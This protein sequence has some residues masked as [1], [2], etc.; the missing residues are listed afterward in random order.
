M[1]SV[2]SIEGALAEKMQAELDEAC[3]KDEKSQVS[4]SY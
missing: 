2:I 4:R 3:G 1:I